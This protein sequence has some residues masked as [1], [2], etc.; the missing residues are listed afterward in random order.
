LRGIAVLMVFVFHYGGGLQSEKPF[1]R[2][3]GYLT[4]TGW[5]G[6]ILF[7]ALSG[8]LIT[9]IIWDSLGQKHLLLNF[10]ARR[11]LRIFPLYFFVLLAALVYGLEQGNRLKELKPLWIY[12]FFL[13]NLPGLRKTALDMWQTFPLYHLWSIAVEEQF[14][15]IWPAILIYAENRR[16]ARKHAMWVFEISI[17]FCI[18]IWMVPVLSVFRFQGFFNEFPITYAGALSLG[19]VLALALRSRNKSGRIGKPRRMVQQWAPHAFWSGIAVYLLVSW[20]ARSFLLVDPMQYVVGLPAIGISCVALIS[21]VL[22][23]GLTRSIVSLAPLVWLGRISYGFY[24]YHIALQPLFDS[25]ANKISHNWQGNIYQTD[26]LLIAFPTTLIVS[27]LSY[28]LLERPVLK[29]K[30]FFPMHKPNPTG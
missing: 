21:I 17:V 28:Y 24:V 27:A 10:Y 22:R 6:V 5:I 13:Q 9:G 15:L 20:Y 1:V 14:Y 23:Y 19:G 2:G 18:C 12:V 25:F 8:F 30:R 11:V 26:R 4:Q 29:L 16:D 3:M 7:F